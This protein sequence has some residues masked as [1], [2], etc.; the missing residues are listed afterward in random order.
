VVSQDFT[1]RLE[2][3]FQGPMD[4][5]LHL[6]REQ[7]V[8]IHEIEISRVIHGYLEYLRALRDL[9]IEL[10]GDFLVMAATLMSIKSRSLLPRE[11]VDLEQEL[12]PR[13]ELIQRLIEYRRFRDASDDLGLRYELRS[14][15]HA[16]G[17]TDN[18]PSPDEP[19]L[20]LG[21]LTC[22]DLLGAFSRLMRET[23]ANRPHRISPER[24]PLRFYVA[25]L[26][27]RIHAA[28]EATL[29]ELFLGVDEHPTRETLVG[30]FCALLELVKLGLVGVSQAG[31][32]SEIA[33]RLKPEHEIDIETIVQAS[34]FDDEAEDEA[35]VDDSAV[36]GERS[37]AAIETPIDAPIDT[38]G[39]IDDERE[40]SSARRIA[41]LRSVPVEADGA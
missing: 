21:E 25:E 36:A 20:D 16:R 29:R 31:D 15:Q 9:D 17:D 28:R 18:E 24:R 22:W 5:L 8:E 19:V 33:I 3:V 1:V 39:A 4:L 35:A 30:S 40:P 6:V 10:A 32:G 13:D 37:D 27:R 34:I 12:D 26:A 23:L 41:P 11:E 7:E 2:R 14:R 38:H